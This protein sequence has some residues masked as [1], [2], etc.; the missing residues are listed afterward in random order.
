MC[1]S[2]WL[3]L[4]NVPRP[5][6]T[7]LPL[8]LPATRPGCSRMSPGWLQSLLPWSLCPAGSPPCATRKILLESEARSGLPLL[9]TS[10]GSQLTQRTAKVS[11]KPYGAAPIASLTPPPLTVSLAY[12]VPAKW[13]SWLFLQSPT[14]LSPTAFRASVYLP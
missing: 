11:T 7:S 2:Y 3:C 12:S 5:Y 1:K 9:R 8:L 4:D 13:S 14:M 10:H 6:S